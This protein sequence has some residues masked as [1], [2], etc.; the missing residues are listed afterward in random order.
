MEGFGAR[1]NVAATGEP[2]RGVLE[3]IEHHEHCCHGLCR[4]GGACRLLRR[5]DFDQL[6]NPRKSR[7]GLGLYLLNEKVSLEIF[8]EKSLEKE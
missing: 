6:E 2:S 4:H 5:F 8:F 3:A 7:F 1:P